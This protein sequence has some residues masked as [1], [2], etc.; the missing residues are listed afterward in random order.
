MKYLQ[1]KELQVQQWFNTSEDITLANLK[2]KVV[3]IHAFQMLCPACVQ[4]SIP[5]AKKLYERFKNEDVI[6]LGLHTVFEHHS[7]MNKEAL[8][9]FI[10]ENRLIFPIAIDLPI[11][12]DFLPATMKEY[13]LQGTPSLIIIDKDGNL[14]VKN[15]GIVDDLEVGLIIGGLL[16]E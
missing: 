12:N 16:K 14:R 7:V 6:I 15:F 8:Q 3:I 11:E 5:Q 4:H 1:A 2:G 9:V 13:D 10:H